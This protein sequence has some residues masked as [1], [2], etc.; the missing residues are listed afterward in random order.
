M[1]NKELDDL[2]LEIENKADGT[3]EQAE[4][5]LQP[6]RKNEKK[7]KRR[8]SF[9]HGITG[10]LVGIMIGVL[11]CVAVFTISTMKSNATSVELDYESKLALI[12]MYLEEYFIDDLDEQMIED[13]IAKGLMENIGDKYAEYYTEKEFQDLIESISGEYAGIGVQIVQNDNNDI[14]VYAVYD[15]SPAKEVGILPGDVIVEAAGTRDFEDMD[16]L[17]AVVRGNPG[18]TVDIVI[19]RND[20]EIPMTVERRQIAIQSVGG[21]MLDDTLGY[22]QIAEFSTTTFPQLKKTVEDLLSQGMKEL[23]FDLRDNPGG[24]YDSVVAVC[25]YIVPEGII[26]TVQDKKGGVHTDNSDANCLD[27]PMVVLVNENSASAAELF[28][29]CLKDYGVAT[30]VGTQTY[31]KGIVQSI[32]QLMD[33]SGLK[34]TTERYYGPAGNCIQDTGIEPDYILELPEDRYEDGIFYRFEDTQLIK[35]AELLGHTLEFEEERALAEAANTAEEEKTEE[36]EN[37]QE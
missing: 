24:D 32:F 26:V 9:L 25:D 31:G 7:G 1:N 13:A 16:A 4:E 18:T 11:A 17:V 8:K 3:A 2:Y 35:G 33:G 12:L 27:I 20:E 15:D 22:I 36:S 29:M 37:I 6:A 14:M 30:I 23:I 10:I 21:T 28:T 34:F 5:N 19:R